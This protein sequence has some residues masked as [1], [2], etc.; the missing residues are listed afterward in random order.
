MNLRKNLFINI[1]HLP[2]LDLRCSSET[3][4][5]RILAKERAVDRTELIVFVLLYVQVTLSLDLFK[6]FLK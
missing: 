5:K 3:I 6:R 1:L 2:S 4:H